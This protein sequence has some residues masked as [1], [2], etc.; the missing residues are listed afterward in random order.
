[1]GMCTGLE[2]RMDKEGNGAWYIYGAKSL[3]L[4]AF[5][6]VRTL[7]PGQK[8]CGFIVKS[9]DDNPAT[10]A[11]LPVRQLA[12]VSEKK[13]H[14]LI[15]TP[16]DL[17]REIISD[18]ETYGFYHYTCLDSDRE[19]LW[20]EQYFKEI[21]R[22]PS[23]HGLH[24]KKA[25][26]PQIYVC[27]AKSS[28]DKACGISMQLP[29]W[30]NTI[31]VGAA[32][33]GSCEA[34]ERDDSGEN[35]SQKNRNYCELTALYWM[36]RNKVRDHSEKTDR[37]MYYGLFHY[38]RILKIGNE[39]LYRMTANDIDI[40]LPFPT[41]HEPDIFEHHTR[42]LKDADWDAMCQALKE[43]HP[44]YADAFPAVLA[45]PYFYNY[46][47]LIAKAEVLDQYCEWLF[48]ILERTEELSS[49]KG[50][51]RADRYIGYLGENLL[52]LYVLYHKEEL[53]IVHTGR[54]MLI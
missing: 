46:N 35:I 6:A 51:E 48:P 45:Q 38:R 27:A 3:A 15:A 2:E 16:E 49:P 5:L 14:I 54:K 17:H 29:Q 18:L 33:G 22:F 21:N 43:L 34:A 19:S 13:I 44:E 11:G 30:V 52:T 40:V 28:R 26:N 1:M 20:M 36:W 8:I 32:L 47:M 9:L 53:R 12:D 25:E 23:I 39:D 7:F 37:T 50:R 41:I 4:G 31:W 10:L 24:W 42:Y